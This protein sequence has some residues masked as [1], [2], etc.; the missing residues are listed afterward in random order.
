MKFSEQWLR[1]WVNP[2]ISTKELAEQ[3][4]MA[5][6]EVD[7]LSPAAPPFEG[8]VVGE[9]LVVSPHPDA[10]KLQSRPVITCNPLFFPK[11]K[12]HDNEQEQNHNSARVNE[13]LQDG[14]QVRV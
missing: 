4:T 5:G 11:V 3:L 7:A 6:L 2:P 9:V 1:E 8:V 10:R 13:D 12:K 14:Y